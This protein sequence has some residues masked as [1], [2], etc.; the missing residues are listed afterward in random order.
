MPDRKA[1]R[2]PTY[3]DLVRMIR[4]TK[5]LIEEAATVWLEVSGRHRWRLLKC[6]DR[7]DALLRR[8]DDEQQ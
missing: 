5:E 2:P 8:I 1:D 3:A 4:E 7:H 6:R